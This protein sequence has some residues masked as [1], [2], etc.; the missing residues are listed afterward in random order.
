MKSVPFFLPFDAE[1]ERLASWDNVLRVC[2]KEFPVVNPCLLSW[3]MCQRLGG[4]WR[5]TL[6]SL[7]WQISLTFLMLSLYHYS[8]HKQATLTSKLRYTWMVNAR[9]GLVIQVGDELASAPCLR[10]SGKQ[11][12]RPRGHGTSCQ[13]E[14]AASLLW[15]TLLAW[16]HRGEKMLSKIVMVSYFNFYRIILIWF[17]IMDLPATHSTIICYE[18]SMRWIQKFSWEL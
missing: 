17:S 10:C 9:K 6:L 16:L 1:L 15:P 14:L 2:F 7:T 5:Y 12:L 13:V 3:E 11:N 4:K 8:N 18:Q